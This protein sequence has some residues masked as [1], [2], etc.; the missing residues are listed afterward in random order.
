MS[1]Q[2]DMARLVRDACELMETVAEDRGL[3]LSCEAP[4]SFPLVGDPR[5]IQRILT[6]L[7]DNAIKFTASG[8]AVKV[9]LSDKERERRP[10]HCARYGFWNPA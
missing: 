6:N 7:L 10:C 8:G 4:E 3:S 1:R 5:M 2:L 9:A